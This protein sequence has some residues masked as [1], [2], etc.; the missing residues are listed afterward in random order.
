MGIRKFMGVLM[1]SSWR[2]HECIDG[3]LMGALMGRF[4][5]GFVAVFVG[6]FLG[7]FVG[8]V[9]SVR[10]GDNICD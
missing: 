10:M 7:A 6:A 4:M 9:I 2:V 5:G 8:E 1:V 3:A